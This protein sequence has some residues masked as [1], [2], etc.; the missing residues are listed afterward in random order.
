MAEAQAEQH[1]RASVSPDKT[2]AELIIAAAVDRDNVNQPL[3]MTVLMEAGIEV[4]DEVSRLVNKLIKKAKASRDKEIREVI[5]RATPPVHGIDGT[6]DWYVDKE[7]ED[8]ED[9]QVSHYERSAFTIVTAEQIIGK[10]VPAK[11]GTD[12]RDVTGKTI[13]AKE[14]LQCYFEFDDSILVDSQGQLIAQSSG[15]LMRE[16]RSCTIEPKL[17]IDDNVDFS[18]GNIDFSGD[19]EI[20]R[21]I[22]D[23]FVVKAE[24]D[25]TVKGFVEDATIIAGKTINIERG[26]AGRER[27]EASAGYDLISK[28]LDNVDAE[29]GRNLSI[30]KEIIGSRLLVHGQVASPTTSLIG[31]ELTVTREV[32]LTNLGSDGNIKTVVHLG[33]VPKLEPLLKELQDMIFGLTQESNALTDQIQMYDDLSKAGNLAPSDSEAQTK[34]IFEKQELDKQLNRATLTCEKLQEK[35]EQTRCIRLDIQQNLFPG[36]EIFCRDKCFLINSSCKGPL[37]I[38]EDPAGVLVLRRGGAAPKPLDEFADVHDR[39]ESPG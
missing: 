4:T 37:T 35:I 25:I 39:S 12:G 16:G 24:G 31:G 2:S 17:I 20:N 10:K 27:A 8:T 26:Y 19:V 6:V 9:K 23:R 3:C 15:V 30:Q 18:T 14:P 13:P 5:A 1:V 36:V 28:Y 33:A 29:I 38:S 34:C 21:D 11:H 32:Q 22:R 7:T